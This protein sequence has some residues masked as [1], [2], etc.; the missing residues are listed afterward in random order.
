MGLVALGV[1][2]SLVL[3][4]FAPR[5]QVMDV[6][7]GIGDRHRNALADVPRRCALAMTIT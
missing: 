6:D 3:G 2:V 1:L 7:L 5:I 4:D